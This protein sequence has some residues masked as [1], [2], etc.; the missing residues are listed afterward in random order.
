MELRSSP[1]EDLCNFF[2]TDFVLGHPIRLPGEFFD[3]INNDGPEAD[4]DAFVSK[5]GHH[6]A[7]FLFM[8]PRQVDRSSYRDKNFFSLVT[9]HVSVR[10]DSDRSP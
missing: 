9:T 1:K 3:V 7:C 6:V 8:R 2:P 5:F 10:V 4:P